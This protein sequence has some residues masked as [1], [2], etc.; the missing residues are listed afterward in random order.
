MPAKL[1][2]RL[3]V[4]SIVA[5]L[6]LLALSEPPDAAPPRAAPDPGGSTFARPPAPWHEAA[7]AARRGDTAQARLLLEPLAD[8][9][10]ATGREARLVLGLWSLGSGENTRCAALLHQAAEPDGRFE[11]W[12]LLGLADCHAA[13]GRLPAAAATLA[14]LLDSRPGSPLRPT[15]A[16]RAAAVAG[17]LG[18][19]ARVQELVAL[20]RREQFG[21]AESEQLERALWQVAVD[22]G[23]RILQRDVARRLLI[24]QPILAS[25]LEVVELFPELKHVPSRKERLRE[26]AEPRCIGGLLDVGLDGRQDVVVLVDDVGHSFRSHLHVRHVA[27]H[28][29]EVPD[30]V[31]SGVSFT[32][33]V[34]NVPAGPVDVDLP[35]AVVVDSF[36]QLVSG[37][38]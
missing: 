20:G 6:S 21:A 8:G 30:M 3:G 36:I 12:R 28:E 31:D 16:L 33:V 37:Q 14:R 4:T 23:D 38:W 10:D 5:A 2:S 25:Q 35:I 34:P 32:H 24:Q 18:D 13:L 7:T 29:V 19:R 26:V 22:R 1:L 9:E 27:P 15:A 11:D 17:E